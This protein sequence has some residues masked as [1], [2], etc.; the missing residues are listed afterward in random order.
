MDRPILWAHGSQVHRETG[1]VQRRETRSGQPGDRPDER[2]G[3][4]ASHQGGCQ[5]ER[6]PPAPKVVSSC[7]EAAPTKLTAAGIRC[8]ATPN[9]RLSARS[10]NKGLA[11]ASVRR[12]SHAGTARQWWKCLAWHHVQRRDDGLEPPSEPVEHLGSLPTTSAVQPGNSSTSLQ[13][14][15]IIDTM[16]QS[17]KQR[18]MSSTCTIVWGLAGMRSD[19]GCMSAPTRQC[20]S[21]FCSELGAMALQ[22]TWAGA[23][24]LLQ[25]NGLA[26]C[27]GFVLEMRYNSCSSVQLCQS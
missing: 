12:Q 11:R 1:H 14:A 9:N 24:A 7:K 21:C 27:V 22:W 17:H 3:S 25:Q 10:S 6:P 15:C 26:L 2:A 4:G 8:Y 18:L 16:L 13:S 19:R 5:G 20:G 23:V